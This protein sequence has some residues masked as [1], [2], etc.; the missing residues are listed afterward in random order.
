[1]TKLKKLLYLVAGVIMITYWLSG[2]FQQEP[3]SGIT[4]SGEVPFGSGAE[5]AFYYSKN[6]KHIQIKT[7]IIVKNLS[8]IS[9]P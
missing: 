2:C 9:I 7:P 3:K 6:G 1:M 4:I 5:V 8:L